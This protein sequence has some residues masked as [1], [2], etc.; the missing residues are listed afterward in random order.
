LVVTPLRHLEGSLP[1][2]PRLLVPAG[3]I[4][5]PGE[6]ERRAVMLRAH[7]QD[8]AE[9]RGGRDRVVPGVQG[10]EA[11]G[12]ATFS[13]GAVSLTANGGT[14]GTLSN[15][16]GNQTAFAG[17][18]G[19]RRVWRRPHRGGR[20]PGLIDGCHHLLTHSTNMA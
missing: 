20:A 5:G 4:E 1:N 2:R 8:P 3:A 17:G 19:G 9:E 12:N 18:T 7:V 13:G 10:M 6:L 14:G 16:S 11:G 15:N